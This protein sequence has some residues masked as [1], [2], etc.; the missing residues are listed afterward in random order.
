MR[1]PSR[2]EDAK[3]LGFVYGTGAV[4]ALLTAVLLLNARPAPVMEVIVEAAP[5]PAPVVMPTPAVEP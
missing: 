3:Y 2:K 1:D 4:A 5:D